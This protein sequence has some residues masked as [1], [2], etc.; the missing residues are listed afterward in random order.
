MQN[1]LTLIAFIDI[2]N[3]ELGMFEH[4]VTR[5]NLQPSIEFGI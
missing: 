4:R 2:S 5:Y 1:T 3:S